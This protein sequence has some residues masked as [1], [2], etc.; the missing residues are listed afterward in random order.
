MY[1]PFLLFSGEP[2]L[3]YP[4]EMWPGSVSSLLTFQPI[5]KLNLLVLLLSVLFA[6]ESHHDNSQIQRVQHFYS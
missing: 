3:L 5:L 6:I 1:L 4:G 2:G